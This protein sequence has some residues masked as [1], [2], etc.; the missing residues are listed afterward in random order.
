MRPGMRQRGFTAFEVVLAIAVVAALAVT[1]LGP[2]GAY[3]DQAQ[4]QDSRQRVRDLKQALEAAYRRELMT[5]S[6]PGTAAL[7]LGGV[8]LAN[9]TLATP[10]LMAPLERYASI[11]A[12]RLAQDGYNQPHRIF[13]SSELTQSITGT[14]LAYRIIAVVS[15]GHNGVLNSTFDVATGTLTPGGDDIVD[16]V[17]G[18]AL[19]REAFDDAQRKLQTVS[20]A[21]QSYFLARYQANPTRSV[22]VDY[23]ANSDPTG[24]ASPNWD[25]DGVILTSAGGMASAEA[26]NLRAA[27]GL[28][29][30]DVTTSLGAQIQV[31]NSS[32]EVNQP[33]Q[34]T[35]A[36]ALP[37]YS[38]RLM[39][40]LPGGNQI[41]TTVIGVYN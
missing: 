40:P 6:L 3:I 7:R 25:A 27:L 22:S 5:A 29:I 14:T 32:T 8:D 37:P 9:N 23:F 17:N 38:A 26:V 10:A 28:S 34:T 31:D 2:F 30:D 41:V 24:A 35:S 1:V 12:A 16:V 20:T 4:K 13:V 11:S 33:D 18:Y 36:R 21:Y 19:V 39:A 15:V